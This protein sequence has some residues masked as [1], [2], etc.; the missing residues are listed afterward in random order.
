MVNTEEEDDDH[1]Y[2]FNEPPLTPEE[3][4]AWL[5]TLASTDEDRIARIHELLRFANE[6]HMSPYDRKICLLCLR[7]LGLIRGGD[8]PRYQG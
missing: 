3:V 7:R 2:I 5:F 1:I 8:P 6:D 4:S